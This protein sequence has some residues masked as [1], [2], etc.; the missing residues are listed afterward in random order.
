LTGIHDVARNLSS[1]LEGVGEDSVSWNIPE[2]SVLDIGINNSSFSGAVVIGAVSSLL[3]VLGR[4][5]GSGLVVQ[6]V[7]LVLFPPMALVALLLKRTAILVIQDE[8]SRFPVA[9]RASVIGMKMGFSPVVLPIVC[10]DT[11]G[12][13]MLGQVKRAPNCLEVEHVEVLVVLVVVNQVNH[14]VVLTVSEGTEV[15][16][17]AFLQVVRIEGTELGFVLFRPIELFYSIVGLG[18][19]ISIGTNQ[20]VLLSE[21][22]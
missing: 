6:W 9:A 4:W 3:A 7:I 8:I 22:T 14:D 18:A 13:V 21:L 5:A 11:E 17:L 10:I 12:F 19:G 16:V 20:T 1:D 15:T 2:N